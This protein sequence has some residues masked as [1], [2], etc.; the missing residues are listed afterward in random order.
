MAFWKNLFGGGGG[1]G[2]DPAPAPG[3]EYKGFVIRATPM[4]VGSEFQLC[5]V[6]EKTIGGEAKIHKFVRAD[7]LSSRDEAVSFAL[8]KGRQIV[9]E[10][11]DGLFSQGWPKVS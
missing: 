3:E 1:G 4:S 10:Q 2:S 5:G 8:A 7:R 9:D 6:I 11:G